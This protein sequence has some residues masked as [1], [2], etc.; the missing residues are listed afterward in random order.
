MMTKEQ[1]I[2]K[3]STLKEHGYRLVCSRNTDP[4]DPL[5]FRDNGLDYLY[6]VI[7]RDY[8]ENGD[9]I[10]WNQL[11]YKIWHLEKYRDR[12]PDTSLYD[13]E[14]NVIISR[15]D[16]ENIQLQLSWPKFSIEE[17]EDI[18]RKFGQWAKENIPEKEI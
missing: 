18:A 12:V 16:S 11:I 2:S 10:A 1:F 13:L 8:D 14:P 7:D 3:L 5:T 6:K 4:A 9:S 17:C 15:S